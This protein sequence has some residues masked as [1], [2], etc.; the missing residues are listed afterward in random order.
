MMTRAV[1]ITLTVLFAALLALAPPPADA[2]QTAPVVTRRERLVDGLRHDKFR[3]TLDDGAVARGNVVRVARNGQLRVEPKHAGGGIP[4]V[5][6]TPKMA[7]EELHRGGLVAMNGGFWLPAAGG[8]PHGVAATDRVMFSGPKTQWGRPGYRGTLA[9]RGDGSAIFS[10]VAGKLTLVRPDGATA[11]I[12]DLNFVPL[13]VGTR[14]GE[15]LAYTSKWDAPVRAPRGSTVVV[16]SKLTLPVLGTANATVKTARNTS[17]MI[18]IPAGGAVLVGYG[19]ARARLAGVA[20]DDTVQIRVGIKPLDVSSTDWVES[21]DVLPGGPLIVRDARMTPPDNWVAEGFSHQ[22]HNGPRHPRTAIG[23]TRS[24]AMLL[25]TVDGRQERSVGMTM[26]EL[27][28]LMMDLG[29][30]YA[31]SLD[32]GGSTTMTVLGKVRNRISDPVPRPVANALVVRYRPD[33]V[34][35]DASRN[36]CPADRVPEPQFTDIGGNA[37]KATIACAAWYGIA[38]GRTASTFAPSRPVTRAQLASF[39]ARLIDYAAT[40][41]GDGRPGRAL[42]AGSG[43]RF[44]DV[45]ARSP[46]AKAISRLAASG[47]VAGGPGALPA[48]SFGP[49]QRVSRAQMAALLVR[50]LAYV[51]GTGLPR[52]GNLFADDAGSAHEAAINRLAT[53]GIVQGKSPGLYAPRALVRRGGMASFLQRTMDVLVAAGMTAPPE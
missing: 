19:R 40:H 25:V 16:V 18:A 17:G 28:E 32:G 36:A 51:R 52:G 29:A 21:V 22:R 37:H 9:I 14:D 46:H 43:H 50:S 3:V 45:P 12:D 35:R 23:A 30:R 8:K 2:A 48:S 10:R 47:I 49:R 42:A 38:T 15:L 7:A 1:A 20:P 44:A 13:A 11:A 26:W 41:P 5:E 34:V 6:T 53:A 31:L 4:G 39:L 27:T 24:G 33:L